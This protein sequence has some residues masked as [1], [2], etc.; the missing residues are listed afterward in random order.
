MQSLASASPLGAK[1]EILDVDQ[2][3][4]PEALQCVIGESSGSVEKPT[5]Q[6]VP[7][8]KIQAGPQQRRK[9]VPDAQLQPPLALGLRTKGSCDDLRVLAAKELF[10][11][12]LR[13]HVVLLD[14]IANALA[15][16]VDE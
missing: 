2:H 14:P 4:Q 16:F 8:E 12:A 3:L 13:I 10:R 6:D 11:F 5:T 9:I 15:I 7:I 1:L